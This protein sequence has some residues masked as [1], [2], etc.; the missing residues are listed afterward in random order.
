LDVGLLEEA[1]EPL[2][3]VVALLVG[4]AAEEEA[5]APLEAGAAELAPAAAEDDPPVKQLESAKLI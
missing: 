4:A 3:G 1:D 5:A 2:E